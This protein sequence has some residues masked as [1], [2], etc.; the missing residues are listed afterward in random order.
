MAD[1]KFGLLEIDGTEILQAQE[2]LLVAGDTKLVPTIDGEIYAQGLLDLL[3]AR[4]KKLFEYNYVTELA[5]QTT[6]SSSYQNAATITTPSLIGGLYRVGF[7][8]EWSTST[9]NRQT[10]VRVQV[11]NS[12]TI[13]EVELKPP[14]SNDYIGQ[15]GFMP[16]GLSAGSHTIDLDFKRIGSNA[17][18][19][20]RYITLELYR[21]ED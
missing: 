17:T 13:H 9:T 4:S 21:V 18:A 1:V 5:E 15:A 10:G 20:V 11:D 8:Y 2:H 7:S 19:K 14:S 16:V 6:T 12:T 3:N